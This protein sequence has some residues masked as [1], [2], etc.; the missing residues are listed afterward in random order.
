MKWLRYALLHF[1][2]SNFGLDEVSDPDTAP[3]W[4]QALAER[5]DAELTRREK[6]S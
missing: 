1:E 4:A 3:D 5:L 6:K 2:W